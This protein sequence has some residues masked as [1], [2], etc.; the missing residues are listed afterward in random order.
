MTKVAS[1]EERQALQKRFEDLK[2]YIVKEVQGHGSQLGRI[3]DE[4]EQLKSE[5]LNCIKE[6]DEMSQV[7][8]HLSEQVQKRGRDSDAALR[9]SE[10]A[11]ETVRRLESRIAEL[12]KTLTGVQ[13]ELAKTMDSLSTL[14]NTTRSSLDNLETLRSTVGNKRSL[15]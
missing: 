11:R 8:S 5:R 12:E 2:G 14:Q 4:V 10:D 6:K 15:R 3:S 7:L 9:V 1:S 13:K